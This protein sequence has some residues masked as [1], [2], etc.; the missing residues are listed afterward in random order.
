MSSGID[1]TLCAILDVPY[2]VARGLEIEAAAEAVLAGGAGV[3]Q[4]RDKESAGARLLDVSARLRPLARRHGAVLVVNDR[5]DVA[6]AVE[7]DGVHVGDEDLPVAIVRRL[8]A[9]G[10]LVGRTARSVEA[11]RAA[12]RD[13][14]SYLGV[15]SLFGSETKS[16]TRLP[17]EAA[18]EI[19]RA[20]RVPVVA[21]G[22]VDARGAALLAGKG[23]V[24][25]AA[26]RALFG[27]DDVGAAARG[28]RAAFEGRR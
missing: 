21:I 19:A 3:L 10:A 12:E 23:F 27:A 1:F 20:V 14:A 4:V 9:P 11:A 13:G 16:A 7:A 8:L 17:V 24:G 22:G 18:A 6:L 15:G 5:A 2:A 25:V 26:S 28:I